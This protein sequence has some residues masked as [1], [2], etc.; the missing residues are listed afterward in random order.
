MKKKID[1][2]NLV[3]F[4][5]DGT[6]YYQRPLQCMMALSLAGYY[7]F[8]LRR[9]KELFVVKKYR[10]IRE[11]S[12][13]TYTEDVSEHYRQA[14]QSYGFSAKEAEIIIQRWMYTVPCRLL[15]YVRDNRLKV[16]IDQL[17]SRGITATVYSDYPVEE[18]LEA[19]EMTFPRCFSSFDPVIQCLK[20]NPV[21]ITNILKEMNTLP[22]DAVMIGDR[23]SK[24]GQAAISAG[25]D[26]C[27]LSRNPLT[28]KK[29]LQTL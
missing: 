28:R 1:Q 26:Y 25:I 12:A 23:M 24:D 8:H 20:P 2:Y 27:I 10:K 18:K 11:V 14:G 6:L 22:Q 4:D 7:A 29:Q 3:I 17:Q 16:I 19:L 5:L 21:G 15:K 9:I 13:G